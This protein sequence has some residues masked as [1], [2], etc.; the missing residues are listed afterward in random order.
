[1]MVTLQLR[2]RQ[3]SPRWYAK[4]TRRAVAFSFY[5]TDGTE[6]FINGYIRNHL[7]EWCKKNCLGRYSIGNFSVFLKEEDDIMLF[8]LAFS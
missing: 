5:Q 4:P 8:K 6:A 7:T 2:A 3:R 1:M